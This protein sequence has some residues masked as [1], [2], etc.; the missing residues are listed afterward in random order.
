MMMRFDGFACEI[1]KS[2]CGNPAADVGGF[3]DGHSKRGEK[4]VEGAERATL[5]GEWEIE[6]K[7]ERGGIMNDFLGRMIFD[8]GSDLQTGILRLELIFA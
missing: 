2:S 6:S 1:H 8:Q 5:D 4:T 7:G 3:N